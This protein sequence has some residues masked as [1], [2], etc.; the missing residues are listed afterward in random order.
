MTPEEKCQLHIRLYTGDAKPKGGNSSYYKGMKYHTRDQLKTPFSREQVE[1][2]HFNEAV[3]LQAALQSVKGPLKEQPFNLQ[4]N[5]NGHGEVYRIYKFDEPKFTMEPW[6]WH[7][8]AMLNRQDIAEY[9]GKES[10]EK[11]IVGRYVCERY[12]YSTTLSRKMVDEW[13]QDKSYPGDASAYNAGC[14][15]V[16]EIPEGF[17]GYDIKDVSEHDEEEEMLFPIGTVFQVKKAR[18]DG[19][20]IRMRVVLP[21]ITLDS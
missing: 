3:C 20:E 19:K 9:D 12:F 21:G 15:A 5:K 6:N 14:L 18:E 10:W 17:Q 2:P 7:F 13:C 16:I 4:P 8:R 11:F 1:S